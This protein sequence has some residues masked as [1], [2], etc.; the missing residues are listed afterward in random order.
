MVSVPIPDLEL[1]S[2]LGR[3]A[4]GV[5][6]RGFRGGRTYAVKMPL[7]TA[8]A[9]G[10]EVAY[11]R[12][13]REAAAL[14][15]VRH[16]SLPAVMEVGQAGDVPYLVMELSN[17]E[18]L[19][20]RLERGALSEAEAISLGAQLA[21]ALDAIHGAGLLHRDVKPQNIVFDAA[22]GTARLV[23]LGSAI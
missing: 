17:G 9:A 16:P 5:V 7:D 21:S 6:L 19:S 23:D 20:E 13:L 12:F 14:A 2:E 11:R 8:P 18:T 3:G 1:G 15:R 22:T 4:H 10:R